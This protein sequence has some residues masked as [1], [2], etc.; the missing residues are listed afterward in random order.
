MV[1]VYIK[2]VLEGENLQKS[3]GCMSLVTLIYF[4]FNLLIWFYYLPKCHLNV[5]I[6][7]NLHV[8]FFFFYCIFFF[9]LIYYLHMLNFKLLIKFPFPFIIYFVTQSTM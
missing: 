5:N 4:Y 3:Y 8:L 6:L 9:I 7:Q 1:C 2:Q